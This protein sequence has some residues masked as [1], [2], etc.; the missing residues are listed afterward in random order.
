MILNQTKNHSETETGISDGKIKKVKIVGVAGFEPATTGSA[1]QHL[2]LAR[3]HALDI[4]SERIMR[5][6]RKIQEK[7]L[8]TTLSRSFHQE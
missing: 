5:I 4:F 1:S 3:L 2:I 7:S 6:S 8:S